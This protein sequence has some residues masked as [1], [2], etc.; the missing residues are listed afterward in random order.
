[1]TD[2]NHA[3]DR[4]VFSTCPVCGD[5]FALGGTEPPRRHKTLEEM[6]PTEHADRQR[7]GEIPETAE[8]RAHVR[9]VH[10]AAGLEPPD[11]ILADKPVEEWSPQD[12][13]DRIQGDR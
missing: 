7:T 4:K 2:C 1:M 12:H 8:Y 11:Q 5:P 3:Q 10:E 6:T 9:R 13:F